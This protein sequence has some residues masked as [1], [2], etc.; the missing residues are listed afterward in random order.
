MPSWTRAPPESLMKTN[1]LPVFRESSHHVNDLGAMDLSG[2]A[3]QH[4]E[5]LAGEMEDAAI[6]GGA[7]GDHAI[8]GNVLAGHAEQ[9]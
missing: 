8:G 5:I 7:S 1:G 6:D 4:G 9:S 3:A 2:S